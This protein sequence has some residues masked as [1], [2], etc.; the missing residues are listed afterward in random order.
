M[1]GVGD[2]DEVPAMDELR[3][4]DGAGRA[5]HGVCRHARGLQDAFGLGGRAGL[6]PGRDSGIE[7]VVVGDPPGEGGVALVA[8]QVRTVEGGAEA[9]P[10]AIVADGDGDPVVIA[11]AG[12]RPRGEP[13]RGR[14]CRCGW[15]RGP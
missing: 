8:R 10:V 6:G 12:G 13:C 5:D 4:V 2:T 3:V 9:G 1:E 14:G 7:I 11:P 15:R